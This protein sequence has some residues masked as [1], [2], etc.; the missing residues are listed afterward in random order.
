[1]PS[2][3]FTFLMLATLAAAFGIIQVAHVLFFRSATPVNDEFHQ[4]MQRWTKI[5]NEAPK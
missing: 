3:E 4:A 5:L 1:M 2:F